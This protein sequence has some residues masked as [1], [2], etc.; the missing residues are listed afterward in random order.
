M[1]KSQFSIINRSTQLTE[2]TIGSE[3]LMA[4]VGEMGD[5]RCGDVGLF[6]EGVVGVGGP[7]DGPPLDVAVVLRGA[8]FF[9]LFI[10]TGGRSEF[11]ARSSMNRLLSIITA[12]DKSIHVFYILC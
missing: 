8:C 3:F 10:S 9:L 5:M 2:G 11:L 12:E 6:C 4:V 1:E 7:E